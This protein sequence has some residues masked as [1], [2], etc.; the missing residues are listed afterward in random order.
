M[1][2]LIKAVLNGALRPFGLRLSHWRKPVDHLYVDSLREAT[3][4][5]ARPL[6]LDIGAHGGQT[7]TLILDHVPQ[8]EVIAFEP[9]REAYEKLE[10]LAGIRH[11]RAVNL[12]LG[13]RNGAAVFNVYRHSMSNSLLKPSS[14]SA[15]LGP[16]LESGAR[17]VQ[18]PMRR[19]DDWL[20]EEQ[21][22]RPVDYLKLDVQGYE[23]RVLQGAEET[24][25]RTR[26][27][28]AEVAF[29]RVYESS[30]MVDDV[31]YLLKNH[32]FRLVR[33]IGY[34]PGADVDQ[35][36]SADFFFTKVREGIPRAC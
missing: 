15:E 20:R 25:S 10:R 30:C 26:F 8:A 34:L 1:R 12:A 3:Q 35:L 23:D 36:V 21:I 5:V 9:S 13:E 14:G 7:T 17:A 4:G 31:C 11:F 24:L 33:S 19:L 6:V 22:V 29:N 2:R 28:L 32:G 16:E 18:V 27:I